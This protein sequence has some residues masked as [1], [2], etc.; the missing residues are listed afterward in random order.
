MEFVEVHEKYFEVKVDI[1]ERFNPSERSFYTRVGS[2]SRSLKELGMHQILSPHG[3]LFSL[4]VE[5]SDKV[6]QTNIIQKEEEVKTIYLD[7]KNEQIMIPREMVEE[8]V[9]K[10]YK[11]E[12]GIK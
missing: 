6:K 9:I 1:D 2:I 10:F 4:N 5:G 12:E 7:Y 3:K 8:F 11:R